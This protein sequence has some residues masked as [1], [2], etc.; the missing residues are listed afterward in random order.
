[1][2]SIVINVY[3]FCLCSV[4]PF[5]RYF[6]LFLFSDFVLIKNKKMC[7]DDF[8]LFRLAASLVASIS[9]SIFQVYFCFIY[10]G[11]YFFFCFV[12]ILLYV[13]N[14]STWYSLLERA[15]TLL[16]PANAW[17]IKKHTNSH[18]KLNLLDG[19]KMDKCVLGDKL[20][21]YVYVTRIQFSPNSLNHPPL[22]RHRWTN[23]TS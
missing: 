23:S 19:I 9:L 11:F 2:W 7:I 16:V 3:Q 14:S 5:P 1:M 10:F 17:H 12:F 8:W 6:V 22:I 15:N 18:R 21:L 4:Y 20:F 13:I